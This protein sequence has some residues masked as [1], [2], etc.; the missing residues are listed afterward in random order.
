MSASSC[1]RI[2]HPA[3]PPRPGP[4]RPGPARL[5]HSGAHRL[6]RRITAPVSPNE[7]RPRIKG[8]PMRARKRYPGLCRLRKHPVICRG[9]DTGQMKGTPFRGHAHALLVPCA[10]RF[11][12]PGVWRSSAPGSRS[13]VVRWRRETE[14][15]GRPSQSGRGG[16][17]V[18]GAVG[19][20]L[21]RPRFI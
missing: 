4:A 12:S 16:R 8:F 11:L 2:T 19:P 14:R 15:V 17:C 7:F 10:G 21:P 5:S 20:H 9:A 3:R 13:I 1:R 18:A 6:H